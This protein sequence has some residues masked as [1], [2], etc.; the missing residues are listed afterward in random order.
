MADDAVPEMKKKGSLSPV[1][2]AILLRMP[3]A[4]SGTNMG[5]LLPGGGSRADLLDTECVPPLSS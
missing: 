3:Y 1:R 4:V 2:G 5:M